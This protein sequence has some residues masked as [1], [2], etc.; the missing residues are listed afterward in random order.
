[1]QNTTEA[2]P[3][4]TYDCNL[5]RLL[6]LLA[7]VM[8]NLIF[9]CRVTRLKCFLRT[10]VIDFL[11]SVFF[12]FKGFIRNHSIDISVN[13]LDLPW[14]CSCNKLICWVCMKFYF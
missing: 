8:K 6:L 13:R 3:F 7:L 2:F 10:H 14:R 4:E 11:I 9:L 12:S 1:M 5:T